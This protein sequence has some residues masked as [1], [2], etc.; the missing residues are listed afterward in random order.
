MLQP[1][2]RPLHDLG[3]I[4][5][6]MVGRPAFLVGLAGRDDVIEDDQ[7]PMRQGDDRCV[8]GQAFDPPPIER[9]QKRGP[10]VAGRLGGQRQGGSQ[11]PVPLAGGAFP[12]LSFCPGAKPAHA[13]K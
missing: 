13:A 7:N 6:V 4:A 9:P 12:P 11:S 8:F 3:P 1:T 5:G 2:D 10:G